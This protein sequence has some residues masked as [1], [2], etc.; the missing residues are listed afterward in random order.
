MNE[1]TKKSILKVQKVLIGLCAVMAVFPIA[2]LAIGVYRNDNK[3]IKN[4]LA[5]TAFG[6]MGTSMATIGFLVNPYR[7]K[8]RN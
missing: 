6:V 2:E 7:K 4:G 1:S 3:A 8:E 5:G